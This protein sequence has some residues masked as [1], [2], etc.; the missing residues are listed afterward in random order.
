MRFDF[1]KDLPNIPSISALSR[2][3]DQPTET[4]Y[5]LANA[6]SL[7]NHGDSRH[8]NSWWIRKR[9]GGWRLVE[10]PK[11]R[12]KKVQRQLLAQIFDRIPPHALA[13]G[14]C[15]GRNVVDFV[16]PHVG[17][18][19]CLKIDLA[20][21]FTHVT[22]GRVWGLLRKAGY[23]REVAHLIALLTTVRTSQ[24]LLSIEHPNS[25]FTIRQ[26]ELRRRHLPQG[27]PTSPAIANLC[28]FG[29]DVRLS[30]LARRYGAHYTRYADD[31][32]I[33]GDHEL[34][35]QA[36][37]LKIV[38]GTIA[39]EEGFAVNFRK[40]KLMRSS[41]RQI[42]TG[43]VLNERLNIT[44]S[45]YDS[46]KA[47]LFNCAQHGPQSQN[48]DAHPFFREHLNGRIMWVEQ[49][50]ATKGKKLRELFERIQWSSE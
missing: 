28:A 20:D 21:F 19:A 29:L 2:L 38:A 3:L 4:L 27:A 34:E 23:N 13:F 32:V 6:R 1:S 43:V 48:R 42:A 11:S 44:R 45:N 17:Q 40:T 15:K 49:L 14:F 50:N 5:W 26:P 18:Q 10:S 33:S 46:L 22:T 12:L 9:S 47:T 24:R 35:R 30:G 36:H 37:R 41:Q 16:K 39:L 7:R 31:I 25:A 8:Y